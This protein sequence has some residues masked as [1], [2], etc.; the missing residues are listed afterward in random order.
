MTDEQLQQMARVFD[1]MSQLRAPGGCPWDRA[2][3]HQSLVPFLLEETYEAIEAIERGSDKELAEELGDLLVEV[4]MQSAIA[5]ERGAFDVG[6]VARTAA[7][8]MVGRHPHVFAD[9]DQL[10]DADDV[11]RNWE[12]LKEQEKPGRTSVLDGLPRTLPALALSAAMQRRQ[13]RKGHDE[14]PSPAAATKVVSAR[15]EQ[16]ERPAG[17]EARLQQI[18][19]LLFALVALARHL[20]VDPEGALRAVARRHREEYEAQITRPTG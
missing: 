16:L 18:G 7:E 1:V 15:L 4:A 8:K 13:A 10:F 14:L 2:Q 9:T 11:L 3:T 12:R 17:P 19:E 20:D 6:D 5:A